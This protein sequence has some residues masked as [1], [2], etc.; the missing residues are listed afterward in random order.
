MKNVS[1]ED[2]IHPIPDLNTHNLE[3]SLIKTHLEK[4]RKLP[5]A[6]QFKEERREVQGEE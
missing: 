2:Q 4:G 1:S 5:E 3:L 6:L